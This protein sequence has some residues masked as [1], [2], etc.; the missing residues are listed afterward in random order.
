MWGHHC[1][2]QLSHLKSYH[3][4]CCYALRTL[5]PHM[6]GPWMDAPSIRSCLEGIV[7]PLLLFNSYSFPLSSLSP[8]TCNQ[9][10]YFRPEVGKLLRMG[11]IQSTC[12]VNQ[13]LLGDSQA[14]PFLHCLWLLSLYNRPS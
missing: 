6:E 4:S 14:H 1:E 10:L 5:S 3:Q 13:V 9:L 12:F 11:Q 8:A 7:L 2:S